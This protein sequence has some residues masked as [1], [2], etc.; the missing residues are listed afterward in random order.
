MSNEIIEEAIDD[1]KFKL[2]D[3][4]VDVELET[5]E[6][7]RALKQARKLYLQRAENATNEVIVLF[8]GEKDRQIYDLSDLNIIRLHAIYRHSIG[9]SYSADSQLDPFTLMYH[10]NFMAAAS[11]N[12]GFGSIGV[13]HMQHMHIKL[14]QTMMANE[15]QYT[16][17]NVTKQLTILKAM[18][19][20]E[21][22]LL[23]CEVSRD[24]E[25]LLQDPDINPWIISYATALCKQTLGIAYSKFQTLAGPNGGVSLG[26]ETLRQEGKEEQQQL[27]EQLIRLTTSTKGMPFTTG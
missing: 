14:L 20:Q 8:L 11:N 7:N 2:G 10:N 21:R 15:V 16:F 22:L 25:E 17:N 6:Y 1:I 27:E 26:G 13:M 23:K 9:T 12:S 24:L 5:P 3:T 18:R 19:R 4:L